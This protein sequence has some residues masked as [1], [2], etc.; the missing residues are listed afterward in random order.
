[1]P[2]GGPRN[3]LPCG[4]SMVFFMEWDSRACHSVISHV[5]ERCCEPA[6]VHVDGY[7]LQIDRCSFTE[8]DG[9]GSKGK[10][11]DNVFL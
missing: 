6:A 4:V 7:F 11:F 5:R 3:R 9:S 10:L 1:M 8:Q 2:A